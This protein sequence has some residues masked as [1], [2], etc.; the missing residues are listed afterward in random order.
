MEANV[1]SYYPVD[2][3]KL[4]YRSELSRRWKPMCQVIIIFTIPIKEDLLI[5]LQ[6]FIDVIKDEG[7][8]QVTKLIE[9]KNLKAASCLPFSSRLLDHP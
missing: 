9:A 6:H 7:M 1:S 5:A 4:L 3:I 2:V 8:Q